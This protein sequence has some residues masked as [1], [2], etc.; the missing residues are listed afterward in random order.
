MGEDE[1]NRIGHRKKAFEGI[2]P[3]IL[4]ELEDAKKK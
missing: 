3:F 1:K 4:E 2:R